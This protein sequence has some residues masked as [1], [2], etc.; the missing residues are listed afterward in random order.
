MSLVKRLKGDARK[1]STT[2]ITLVLIFLLVKIPSAS[3]QPV[4]GGFETGDLT[5]WTTQ[6]N[7]EALQ[8]SNFNPSITP[9]E[10]NYFALLSTGPDDSPAPNDGDLDGDGSNDNDVTI[11][12]QTFTSGSGSLSFKWSWL[13]SEAEGTD[14]DDF[15]LVRLDGNTIL[16]G[17]VDG[18]TTSP[19]PDIPTDHVYYAVTSPGPTDLS[20]FY[21]GTNGFQTYSIAISAG[22]HTIEF[23]V[24]EAGDIY[25]DSG[26][27][28]DAFTAPSPAPTPVGGIAIPV[29]KLAILAPY[30]ALI[31]LVGAVTVAVATTRRR[32]L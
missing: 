15:F 3:A 23:I 7:V 1:A 19:F 16:S 24:A 4:N 28:V 13:T 22:T 27:L 11:L 9:P 29:N 30:L 25:Y 12:S 32:K 10:G 2:L 5:G 21:E 6:G 26:L 8:A 18:I 14:K 17:S 31:G 20:D